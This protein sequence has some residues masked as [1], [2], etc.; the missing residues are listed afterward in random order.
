MVPRAS[1][2]QF[3]VRDPQLA[4]ALRLIQLHACDPIT[5][6]QLVDRLDIS[7]ST[8]EKR[9]RDEL[10]RSPH[11]EL[12]RVQLDHAR[13]LLTRTPMPIADI[14]RRCGFHDVKRFT[15]LFREHTGVPPSRYRQQHLT[16]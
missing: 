14:A 1:S 8:L 9:F 4:Q 5:V 15:T 2:D 10:G 16:R 12:K 7:R 6:Y 13:R 3:A 11:D